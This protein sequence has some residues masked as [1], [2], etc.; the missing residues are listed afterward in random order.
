[1][2]PKTIFNCR[3]TAKA[4][5][6]ELAQDAGDFAGF[7]TQAPLAGE[8]GELHVEIHGQANPIHDATL[9]AIC[10]ALNAAEICYPTPPSAS[11]TAQSG[12]PFSR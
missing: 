5:G 2:S 8:A 6:L 10:T 9:E 4:D 3:W 12:H 11:S 1:L 7:A